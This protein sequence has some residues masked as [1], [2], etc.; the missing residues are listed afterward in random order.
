MAYAAQDTESDGDRDGA[1]QL[2]GLV[3][4]DETYVG[5][6]KSGGKR[7]RGTEKTKVL[8]A[9]SLSKKQKPEFVKMAVSDDITGDTLA[10]CAEQAIP[11]GSTISSDG[12]RSYLKTFSTDKYTHDPEKYDPYQRPEHVRWLYRIVANAKRFIMGDLSWIG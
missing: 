1:Y 11:E 12:Y 4:M 2:A 5:G 10:G 7:G 9:V 6:P 3:E 8:A